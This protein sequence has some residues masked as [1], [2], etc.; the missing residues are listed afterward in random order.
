VPGYDVSGVVEAL[1]DGVTGF[2][3]GD[4]VVGGIERGARDAQE[5]VPLGRDGLFDVFVAENFGAAELVESNCLHGD[6]CFLVVFR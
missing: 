1:G 4:A 5:H 2:E 6:H 3:V